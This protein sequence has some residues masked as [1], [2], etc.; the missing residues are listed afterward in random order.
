MLCILH[1]SPLTEWSRDTRRNVYVEQ[2][3]VEQ[4]YVEQVG[5][6][7]ARA[8]SMYRTYEVIDCQAEKN[9]SNRPQIKRS[10]HLKYT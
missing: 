6:G 4:I 2:I 7:V 1:S 8:L 9:I 3:H 5:R 10:E